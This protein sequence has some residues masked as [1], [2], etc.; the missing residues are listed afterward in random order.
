MTGPP[1]KYLRGVLD[2]T[3]V[4]WYMV[5]TALNSGMGVTRWIAATGNRIQIPKLDAAQQA[6]FITLLDRILADKDPDRVF[7]QN[8][9]DTSALE[10]EVDQLVYAL[11]RLTEAEIAA[12]EGK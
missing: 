12:V 6:S 8:P 3:L 1:I 11:Y 2:S 10:A 5:Q 4:I 9:T 7:G